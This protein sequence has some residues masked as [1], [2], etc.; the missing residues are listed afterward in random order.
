[1]SFKNLSLGHIVVDYYENQTGAKKFY[2]LAIKS[3]GQ[4]FEVNKSECVS[5]FLGFKKNGTRFSGI[6][7][8]INSFFVLTKVVPWLA[9]QELMINGA[10]PN[11]DWEQFYFQIG[12][13]GDKA[14][15]TLARKSHV[16]EVIKSFEANHLKIKSLTLGISTIYEIV[17]FIE[18]QSFI[19]SKFKIQP[20]TSEIIEFPDTEKSLDGS[21]ISVADF[22]LNSFFLPGLSSFLGLIQGRLNLRASLKGRNKE[23]KS[24]FNKDL[25]FKGLLFSSVTFLL[26]ILLINSF[27]YTD[28][29]EDLNFY[30]SLNSKVEIEK[31][32]WGQLEEEYEEKKALVENFY[33]TS[34]SNSTYFLNQIVVSVPSK[35]TLSKLKYQPFQKAIEQGEPIEIR[36]NIIMLS[37][38]TSEEYSFS[39]W[40]QDMERKEWVKKIEINDYQMKAGDEQI[41]FEIEITLNE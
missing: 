4:E 17:P 25:L 13:F 21:T 37:G 9:D 14:I 1:M 38:G 5:S 15:L 23:L 12:R 11:I 22:E 28:Y 10:F 7:L 29:Y 16:E 31:E 6:H 33:A 19:T 2:F 8:N 34:H 30:K 32:R 3:N 36:K 41:E 27:L 35:I 20:G 18:N 39:E 40:I 24:N 26:L